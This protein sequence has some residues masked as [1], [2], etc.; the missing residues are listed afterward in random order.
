[1]ET[2]IIEEVKEL[3]A[4]HDIR[5]LLAID[6]TKMANERT[7]LAYTRTALTLLIIGV[8]FL[9]FIDS[10]IFTIVGWVFIPCAI[11][12]FIQGMIR[13]NKTKKAIKEEK[14]TLEEMLNAEYC[15]IN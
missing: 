10:V 3:K 1:M 13:F 11:Y 15:R 9:H 5:H 14:K 7:V 4:K 2:E 8:T 12:T 6:R